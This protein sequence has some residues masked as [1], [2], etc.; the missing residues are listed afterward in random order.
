MDKQKLTSRERRQSQSEAFVK[1]IAK[2]E[3]LKIRVRQED[4][5]TIWFG[6]GVFGVV[7]W[8][9]A[10]PTLI[11]I[12]IGLW[13]D[14]TWPSRYSWA[15]TLLIGGVMLG[16][17]NESSIGSAAM[18][19]LAPLVDHLDADGPLLL[20]EDVATGLVYDNGHISMPTGYGLGVDVHLIF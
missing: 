3:R 4:D 11:G 17:M 1:R 13:I 14:Q 20:S 10:I 6:L 15:L 18:V 8:S 2:K 5:E 12:A 19:H 7:G 16:C 9:V